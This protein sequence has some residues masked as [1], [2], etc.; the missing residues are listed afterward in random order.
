MK[1]EDREV[2]K[3]MIRYCDDVRTL[4]EE[5]G[6]DFEHYKERISFQ[7]SCNMCII[8][9]GELVG[10]LSDEFV[11]EHSE[12]PWHAIK[13]MRNLHAHDYERVDLEIVWDTLTNEIPEL[14]VTLEKML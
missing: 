14:R 3:R 5:Y 4:L 6:N 1:N 2:L 8:Q 11:N 10:R 13:A 12:V 7:Y 9:I